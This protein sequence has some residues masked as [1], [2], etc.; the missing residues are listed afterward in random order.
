MDLTIKHYDLYNYLRH[1][2]QRS[3]IGDSY[4]SWQ[5][6][7]YGVPQGSILGPLLFNADLCDLF[8]TMNRYDIANYADDNTPYVSGRNM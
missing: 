4:S 7:L 3:R 2:K 8:I 6:I 5:E 1:R